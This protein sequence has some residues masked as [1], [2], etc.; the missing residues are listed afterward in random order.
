M[1]HYLV[2]AFD[3]KYCGFW[4]DYATVREAEAKRDE[5]HRVYEAEWSRRGRDPDTIPALAVF[6]A[7]VAYHLI[8]NWEKKGLVRDRRYPE[9]H[10]AGSTVGTHAPLEA[11]LL[12]ELLG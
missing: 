10:D 2:V 12:A 5:E 7:G 11:L 6:N 3:G 8:H 9:L 1:V 4:G